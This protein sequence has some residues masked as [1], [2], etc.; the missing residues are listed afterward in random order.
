METGIFLYNAACN[1]IKDSNNDELKTIYKEELK[2]SSHLTVYYVY[3]KLHMEDELM[4]YDIYQDVIEQLNYCLGF[5]NPGD[6]YEFDEKENKL[7][8]KER[9]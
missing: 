6:N 3:T 4:K 7:K 5:E 1:Y 9:S 2:K 8:K